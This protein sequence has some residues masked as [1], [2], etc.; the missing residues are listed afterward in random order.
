MKRNSKNVLR[1]LTQ[2]NHKLLPLNLQ[3]FA[4]GGDEDT[5]KD[6]EQIDY[7]ALY[8]KAKAE[9]DKAS[10]EASDY[11]KALKAKETEEEAKKREKEE[12]DKKFM[13]DLE[14]LKQENRIY[15]FKNELS[16]GGF[17]DAEDIENLSK[18]RLDEDDS[19]F[20]KTLNS[21]IDKKLKSQKEDLMKEFKRTG[22]VPDGSS[23]GDNDSAL[24]LAKRLAQLNK[25]N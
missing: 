16:K 20:A 23:G 4:E 5:S 22:R 11:K 10:K 14:K 1:D 8:E 7:K 21:I 2:K 9:K 17:L 12:N 13:E 18:V 24:D 25:R 6:D 3:L 15:K 19:N